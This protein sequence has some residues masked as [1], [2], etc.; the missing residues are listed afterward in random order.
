MKTSQIAKDLSGSGGPTKV[1]ADGWKHFIC[2]K[3]YSKVSNPLCQSIAELTKRF[4][5][6]DIDASHSS[7][8]LSCR[9]VPLNKN[10]GIWPIGIGEILQRIMAKAVTRVLQKDIKLAGGTLQTCTRIDGGIEAAIHAMAKA[11]DNDCT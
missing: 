2:N 8:L 9:L 7:L 3:S 6:E 1:D 11:F 4:C 5:R 10:P